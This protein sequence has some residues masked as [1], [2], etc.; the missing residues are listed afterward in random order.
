MTDLFDSL[1]VENLNIFQGIFRPKYKNSIPVRY[2]E[3]DYCGSSFGRFRYSDSQDYWT[4][5][6]SGAFLAADSQDLKLPVGQVGGATFT[7][8]S[9][10]S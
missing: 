1:L 7:K 2:I 6:H 10:H 8:V 4:E 3:L 5:M 9:S